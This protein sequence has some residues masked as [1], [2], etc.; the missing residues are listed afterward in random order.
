[1]MKICALLGQLA[2]SQVSLTV[3]NPVDLAEHLGHGQV[4]SRLASFGQLQYGTSFLATVYYSDDKNVRQACNETLILQD[5][6]LKKTID[7]KD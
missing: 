4:L 6:G 5:K 1:M 3:V 2:F 7:T